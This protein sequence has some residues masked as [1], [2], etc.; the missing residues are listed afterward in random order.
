L[1]AR[2]RTPPPN[3]S[4]GL[5]AR[6]RDDVR[7]NIA[8]IF[9]L[10]LPILLGVAG[11]VTEYGYSLSVQANNQRTADLAAYA[12]ALAYTSGNSTTVMTSAAKRV[13]E[14]NGVT[15]ANVAVDLVTSPRDS[16]N[17]A[18][19]AVVTVD[20]PLFLA[21]IVGASN[22]VRI[23][24]VSYAEIGAGVTGCIIALD[25]SKSG[26]TLSGGTKITASSCAVSSNSKVDV[27]CGTTITAKSVTYGSNLS[28]PCTGITANTITKATT[29]DPLA[30]NAAVATARARFTTLA[31]QTSPAAPA[32]TA[33]SGGYSIDFAYNPSST[34]AQATA[35]G[36]TA[37]QSGST[38]T[39]TCPQGTSKVYNF[40][41]L[42][43]GGGI[44]FSFNPSGTAGTT[45]NFSG[46][47]SVSSTTIFGP[48]IYNFGGAVSATSYGSTT[49]GDG[50]YNFAQ[51]FNTGGSGTVTF[52][53]GTFNFA[54]GII[55]AGS[56]VTTFGAGTFNMGRS[57]TTCNSSTFSLC[58]N[59][60]GATT[61][62]GP[63]TFKFEGGFANGGGSTLT[64]GS[65]T[66]NI[67]QLGPS[68]AGDAI[69]L[70]G[71]SKTYLADATTFELGGNLW[72][73]NG[74]G[75][76]LVISAAAQHDIRGSVNLAGAVIMGAG[77]YTIDGY[78]ALGA[79][80]GGGTPCNGYTISVKATG[81][82]IVLSGKTTP[83]SGSCSGMAFCV[84]AGYSNIEI[85]APST[86]TLANLAVIGP[87]AITAGATFAEGGSGGKISGA[88]YFPVG[89]ISM[90][91]G[92]G[93]AGGST[94]LQLIG[95]LISLS[96]GTT[97][98]S[99]CIAASSGGGSRP[100]LVQ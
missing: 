88:F 42:T 72:G 18:V 95:S 31:A 55:T 58:N 35:A 57:A 85:T 87:A 19:R 38:W 15:P 13:G 80:G 65:G 7:G 86:G 69:N 98:A 92:A 23:V 36:C 39:L 93:V 37:S 11:L 71:G 61:F 96:G 53:A 77:V 6:F 51:T 74:G 43:F 45:Y 70:G 78:F 50:T 62:A 100:R 20:N 84:A 12:G 49:F 54:K 60:S 47:L 22:T 9:A 34:Q 73:P 76:C 91:G 24:T 63:S 30:G 10:T 46:P 26:V 79:S 16:A 90:S 89:A 83:A 32:M 5:L 21:P 56:V 41:N 14:L 82:N 29:T 25:G 33:P 99:E 8:V 40:A 44:N 64:M 3:S 48:G 27:P 52:G 59:S 97:A 81:V 4:P 2:F 1:F 28:Q 67:F 94:C 17:K 75:S 66:T 68:G